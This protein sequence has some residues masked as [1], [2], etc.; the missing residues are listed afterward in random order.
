M[1]KCDRI[2]CPPGTGHEFWEGRYYAGNENFATVVLPLNPQKKTGQKSFFPQ[3]F[4]T[5]LTL[6]FQNLEEKQ[7]ISHPQMK[8]S[9][10][11]SQILESESFN[12]QRLSTFWFVGTPEPVFRQNFWKNFSFMKFW[13][14]KKTKSLFLQR[15]VWKLRTLFLFVGL[16]FCLRI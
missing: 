2:R 1:A 6:S 5:N 14:K 8:Y 11:P 7:E 3:E 16:C 4:Q 15:F 10:S 13:D 9:L 12:Q